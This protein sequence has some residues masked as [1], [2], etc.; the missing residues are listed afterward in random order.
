M[1]NTPLRSILVSPNLLNAA[2]L[3]LISG[4]GM[5]LFVIVAKMIRDYS[6][7]HYVSGIGSFV[8]GYIAVR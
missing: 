1:R 3:I 2:L 5:V 6:L 8:F 7:P 4:G